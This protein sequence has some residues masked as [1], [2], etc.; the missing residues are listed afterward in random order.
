MVHSDVYGSLEVESLGGNKY[1]LTFVGD[2]SHKVWVY[3]LKM[4][5]HVFKYFKMFHAT[6]KHE[7]DKKL[8]CLPSY[9]IGKYSSREFNAYCSRHGIWHEKMVPCTPQHNNVAKRMNRVIM[10]RLEV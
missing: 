10:E 7:I 8:K 3:F 2:A 4:R 5:V 9:N 6:V 1:F